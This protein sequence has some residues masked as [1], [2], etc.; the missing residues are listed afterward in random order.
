[1]LEIQHIGNNCN[2]VTYTFKNQLNSLRIVIDV[3][4]PDD[5]FS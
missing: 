1:M 5:G 2:I 4:L 3:Y